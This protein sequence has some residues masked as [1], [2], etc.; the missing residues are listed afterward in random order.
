MGFGLS[1][2]TFAP[3]SLHL[4][5]AWN[6]GLSVD[7]VGSLRGSPAQSTTAVVRA[8]SSSC[9]VLHGDGWTG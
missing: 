2:G 5:G 8:A 7:I 4:A 6:G 1:S 9:V 3:H